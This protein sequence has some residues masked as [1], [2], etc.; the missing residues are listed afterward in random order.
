MD[1]SVLCSNG[2]IACNGG[3]ATNPNCISSYVNQVFT[4]FN[5]PS[6]IGNL[7]NNYND[8]QQLLTNFSVLI[9]SYNQLELYQSLGGSEAAY[10]S[11]QTYLKSNISAYNICSNYGQYPNAATLYNSCSNN[12]LYPSATTLYNTCS[13][14]NQY[15]TAGSMYNTCSNN[16]QVWNCSTI[17]TIEMAAMAIALV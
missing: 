4:N 1:N 2:F 14:N 16:G 3:N 17:L 9:S 8:Y 13:N 12:G 6:S 7:C 11:C 10:Q 5:Q 15:P